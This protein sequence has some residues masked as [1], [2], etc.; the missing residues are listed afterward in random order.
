VTLTTE[1]SLDALGAAGSDLHRGDLEQYARSD[2]RRS[3]FAVA[4]SLLPFLA[5]WAA[6]FA[7]FPVS[8]GL[9]LLLAVPA[10]GFMVRT[11]ILFHDCVHGSLLEGKRSNEWLGRV[12]GLLA[13]TPFARWRYEHL[14]HHATAGDL[15]RRGVG[16]VPMATVAEFEAMS[17]GARTGYRLYRNPFVMYLL[18]PIY[19][20]FIMQRM[21]SRVARRRMRRSVW[22]TNVAALLL[23]T[24][25]VLTFGWQATLLVE[26]PIVV[27]AGGAGIWL[28]YVQHQ[29]RGSYWVHTDDWSFT[30]AALYGS[31]Y[32]ALPRVLQFFTGNI[33]FHHVHHLNPK[34]PN[35]NL[36]RAHEEQPFL[37][38]VPALSMRDGLRATQLKLYDEPTG[39]L[40]TWPQVR[41]RAAAHSR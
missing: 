5:L 12:L 29:Y 21:Q 39:D 4:T 37:R 33:G 32:L 1:I 2:L 20:T 7:V 3:L 35:Y 15:D 38:A 14:V 40:V 31:S 6:M 25:L 8:Y 18:G 10:A 30:D 34:I 11:Y 26:L 27:M 22:G 28:F 9:V 23:V 36:Q 13:F 19:S 16:D 41:S 24:A 17:P